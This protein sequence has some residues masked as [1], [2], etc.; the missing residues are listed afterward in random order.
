M[1]PDSPAGGYPRRGTR[2]SRALARRLLALAGWRVRGELPFRPKFVLIVAP[3]TSNWD[4][5]IGVLAMFAT[6][7]RASWLG[8]HTLFRFPL[9]PLLCWLGGEPIDRSAPQ[10]T[11]GAAVERFRTRSHWVLGLS[12]EGTRR[13][14]AR[15]KTGFHRIAVRAGVPIVPV[16]IDYRTRTVGIG[17]L[18]EPGPDEA[19]DVARLR[20]QFR[21][22]M[23][24]HPDQFLDPPSDERD[25]RAQ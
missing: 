9:A 3:H 6:G 12:P 5:V 20:A 4:F 24:R 17:A 22:D 7:L 14:V 10:G 15:W 11:T 25:E 16:W 2:F 19:A 1:T 8:K 18:F 13:P 23:A 21:K